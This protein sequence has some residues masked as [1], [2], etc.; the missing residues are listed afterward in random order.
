[1]NNIF[2]YALAS[3]VNAQ[4]GF[5]EKLLPAIFAFLLKYWLW[6]LLGLTVI[7]IIILYVYFSIC[8]AKMAKKTNTSNS[9]FAWIPI[10][11]IYLMCKIAGKSGVWV[12][13]LLIPI[14]SIIPSIILPF[15]LVK[16][17]K[18]SAWLAVLMLLPVN[19]LKT[20]WQI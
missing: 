15:A 14:I 8:L 16:R 12:L 10:F 13:W 1:M 2:D 6:L 19:K 3:V 9:W 18:K 17:F 4:P 5:F 11:N 20:N 7:P